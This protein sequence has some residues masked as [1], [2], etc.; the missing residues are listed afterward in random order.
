MIIGISHIT[1][2]VM[3]ME[4][5]AIFLERIFGAKKVYSSPTAT[6]FLINDL[7]IA[8]NQGLP[9]SERSCNHI[10]FS[11]Q[12]SEFDNYV[13]RIRDVGAEIVQGRSRREGEGRS[14][15]FYDYDNHLFE[16]HTGALS[17]RV[18][19]VSHG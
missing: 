14:I 18:K 10:A 17:E 19:I 9:L 6:Y 13:E 11:I 2:V 15:Y 5:T 12:E 8:L 3:D 16:L 1:F 7:W 4:R